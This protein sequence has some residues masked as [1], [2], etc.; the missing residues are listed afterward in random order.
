MPA[1][2]ELVQRLGL[3]PHPEGGYYRET[4]RDSARVVRLAPDGAS[5][6]D[7]SRAASTAIYYMLCGGAYSA[8]HRIDADEV[9]HFY[10]GE[11]LDIH[12]LDDA[13]RLSSCRLGNALEHADAQFQAVVP[14][15]CWFAAECAAASTADERYSFVGCTVAPGFEFSAFEL[16]DTSALIARYPAHAALLSRLAPRGPMTTPGPPSLRSSV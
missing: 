16:A 12:M 10:A 2:N 7:A 8:W 3:I 6:N 14:A 5:A 15:R 13:G 11:P 4:H 1:A 9:W